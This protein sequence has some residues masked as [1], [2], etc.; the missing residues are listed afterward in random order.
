MNDKK[1]ELI[2]GTFVLVG[3][4][5]VGFLAF[6]IGDAQ[7]F[8]AGN[9]TLNAR[10]SDVGG[11]TEGSKVR[12]AGVTVGTVGR[13]SLDP[14]TYYANVELVLRPE[15][16]LDDDT[17]ASVKTNGLIGDKFISLLPGG[18]GIPLSD[19]EDIIE[20]ESAVDFEGLVSRIAFGGVDD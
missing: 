14:E 11:L 2:A 18:S 15:I 5:L 13:I 20:T 8:A 10:F 12:L 17:I 7:I 3:L 19:G 6:Q 9:Y 1:I 16:S 4:V